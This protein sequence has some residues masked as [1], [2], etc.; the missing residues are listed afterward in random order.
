MNNEWS[1]KQSLAVVS[2]NH[3]LSSLQL[4]QTLYLNV[5][6]CEQCQESLTP[7]VYVKLQFG[8]DLV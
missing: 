1:L 3:I 2:Q 7:S 5:Y 6:F 4:S 8:L